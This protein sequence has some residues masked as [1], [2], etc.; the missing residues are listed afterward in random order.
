MV[1]RS[2]FL[3][4]KYL[5][6]LTQRLYA[7]NLADDKVAA[8]QAG[9]FNAQGASLDKKE[10]VKTVMIDQ[11]PIDF[12]FQVNYKSVTGISDLYQVEVGVWWMQ[13]DQVVKV[14]RHGYISKSILL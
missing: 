6:Q 10:T 7:S 12:H 8:I 13:H 14:L 9:F 1:Y 2:F 5:N 11:K 3:S 4:V